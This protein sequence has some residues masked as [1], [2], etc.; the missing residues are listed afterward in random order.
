MGAPRFYG[1]LLGFRARQRLGSHWGLKYPYFH[2][3]TGFYRA[4]KGGGFVFRVRSGVQEKYPYRTQQNPRWINQMRWREIQS[5]GVIAAQV[6]TDEERIPYAE[7][8]K[9][10]R[11]GSWFN[12]FMSDW[13]HDHGPIIYLWI[14]EKWGSQKWG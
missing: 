3:E 1:Y 13:L 6:L 4:P 11:I 12:M 5:D 8:V 7:R 9:G 10:T 14:E 2:P